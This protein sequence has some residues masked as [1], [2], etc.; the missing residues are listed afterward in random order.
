M[1]T[2]TY[3]EKLNILEVIY[4]GKVSIE[5]L[6]EFGEN[7]S[8]NKT[9]PRNIKM[10]TDARNAEYTFDLDKIYVMLE[11]LKEHMKNYE[12]VIAAFIQSKPNETALSQIVEDENR[13]PNYIHKIFNTRQSALDWLLSN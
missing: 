9:L 13:A 8:K 10:L 2:S 7:F 4:K 3:N 1:I 11:K 6:I 5:D 12:M